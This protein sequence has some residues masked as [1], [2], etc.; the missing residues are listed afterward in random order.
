M[1]RFA[2]VTVREDGQLILDRVS[3]EILEHDKAVLYGKSGSGKT[4]IMTTIVGAHIPA[5]GAVYFRGEQVTER[6]IRSLRRAVSYIGQEPVLG[7]DTV[8]EAIMLPFTF[9]GFKRKVPDREAV[10]QVLDRLHLDRG[11]LRKETRVI[12]GGEKQRIAIA[13]EL[14]LQKSIFV[15]DEVT[16]ALDAESKR[17]VV[18][19]FRESSCTIVSASHDPEWMKICTR[20]F[21][22]EGGK[23]LKT[24]DSPEA[25]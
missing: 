24:S 12:S 6:T 21:L 23:I 17:A 10:V 2:D 19:F 16:S 20:F 7:A 18:E 22:V 8:L 11:I 14:L 13:R 3:L 25:V 4:T 1:I 5:E 15:L 9:K